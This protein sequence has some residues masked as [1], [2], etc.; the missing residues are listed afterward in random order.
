MGSDIF[1]SVVYL[2]KVYSEKWNVTT[3][4]IVHLIWVELYKFSCTNIVEYIYW[5]NFYSLKE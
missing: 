4:E 3:M 1:F 2:E 5:N